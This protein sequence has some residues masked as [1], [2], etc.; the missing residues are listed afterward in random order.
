M[1]ARRQTRT[2]LRQ[3]VLRY[4]SATLPMLPICFPKLAH[5]LSSS[6]CYS[7]PIGC[8]NLLWGM[9]MIL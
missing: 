9:L 6:V 7:S 2:V 4:A 1:N 5:H 8:R 3:A